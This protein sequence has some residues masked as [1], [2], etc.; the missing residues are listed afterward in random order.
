MT[1]MTGSRSSGVRTAARPLLPILLGGNKMTRSTMTAVVLLLGFGVGCGQTSPAV[2]SDD[3]SAKA[4]RQQA[5][6]ESAAATREFQAANAPV[7]PPNLAATGGNNPQGY[8]YDVSVYNARNEHLARAQQL[9]EHARQH[10][11]A[12]ASLETFEDAECKQFPPSTRSACPLLGPVASITDIPT[13]VRVQLVTGT[14]ADAVLAH[15]RC[16]LAFATARGFGEAASCP[17]YVKGIEV[18]AGRDPNTI[19]IVSGDVK[20]VDTIRARGRE[21]AVFVR[22]GL[23]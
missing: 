14:R 2:R 22:A 8:Y 16:H 4:Q 11:A 19:E 1:W 3:T 20:V 17:L 7:P 6:A 10:E 9:S 12:A 21:E 13:G 15:M 18:R 5:Q 23:K